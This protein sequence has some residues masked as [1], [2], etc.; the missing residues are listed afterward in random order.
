MKEEG[1]VELHED[2]RLRYR[3]FG[4]QR[5]GLGGTRSAQRVYRQHHISLRY[6]RYN[7]GTV[8]STRVLWGTAAL[9]RPTRLLIHPKTRSGSF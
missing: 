3:V 9:G 4:A 6:N 8:G 7:F 2:L 1:G 5:G